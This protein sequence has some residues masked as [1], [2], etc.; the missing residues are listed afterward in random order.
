MNLRRI[1]QRASSHR[2]VFGPVELAKELT[3]PLHERYRAARTRAGSASAVAGEPDR[4]GARHP[5]HMAQLLGGAATTAGPIWAVTMVKN[6]EVRIEGSVRQLVEG[7]VDVVVVADNLSTDA[8]AERLAELSRE[9][10]L[11]VVSDSRGRVLPGAEDE[12]SGTNGVTVWRV[13]GGAFR[14]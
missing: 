11:I 12:P 3:P 4:F 13:V 2:A 6:E 8:T 7:G 5:W 9:L 10:P 1:V 14:C